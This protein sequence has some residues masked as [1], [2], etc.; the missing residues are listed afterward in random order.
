ML[1]ALELPPRVHK[2]PSS[3]LVIAKGERGPKGVERVERDKR[4][5]AQRLV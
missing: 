3:G 1:R 5:W 4:R 2:E